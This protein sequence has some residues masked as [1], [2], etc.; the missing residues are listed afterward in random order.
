MNI[1]GKAWR[2]IWLENDG[3]SIGVIDQTKLPHLFQTL[4]LKSYRDVS[5]AIKSMVV[6]G[7]PLIGV[8]GAYGVM[9]AL[10]DNPSDQSLETASC[11]LLETRPTA[12]NLQWA[13]QRVS[14]RVFNLPLNQR[15][16]EAKLE[17]ELI[18]NEDINMC[19][20][21][22]RN[23]V[24]IL[25]DIALKKKSYPKSPINILTHCNAGWLGT[26]DWGTALAPIYKA[27]R[28][29]MNIHVWV[30]ETRPRNQG[31]NL[32]A[33]EL[34]CE[35]VPHT[36]I[37][38]NAGGHL[39]QSGQ[40]DAVFVGSDR[41]TRSGDV[42]N[43][44]GTYLKALASNDN[45]LPFYV[46]APYSTIDW[47]VNNGLETIPIEYRSPKEVTHVLGKD[48]RTEI[49]EVQICNDLTNVINPAFDVT[50]SRL[51]SAIITE[52]G[53]AFPKEK[54]LNQLYPGK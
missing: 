6:R 42:C 32:T 35:G 23:G 15:A 33:Y 54:G 45:N 51:V 39:M 44:I 14:Q 13:I 41:I 30:D 38:D 9:L 17:A 21:I 28:S 49:S 24:I 31:S 19:H 8:A 52:R 20:S 37:V 3:E 43:K 26:V 12:I 2:T 22:G 18:A 48:S 1:N 29:G 25:R 46:A 53:I 4:S 5:K 11:D 36:L 50:P 27:Y 47:T 16:K 34:A 40:V 7:A 10:R